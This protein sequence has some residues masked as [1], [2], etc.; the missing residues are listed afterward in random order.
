V[1]IEEVEGTAKELKT[2]ADNL[3]GDNII[4]IL[5]NKDGYILCKCGKGVDIDMVNLLRVVGKGG[6]RKDLAQGK[7]LGDVGEVK[8]RLKREIE[9]V[10]VEYGNGENK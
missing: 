6:G 8:E 1:L 9:K 10:I 4:V 3:V 7:Y 2:T 5:L